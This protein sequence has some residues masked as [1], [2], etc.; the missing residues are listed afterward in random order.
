MTFASPCVDALPY[1][2]KTVV[3]CGLPQLLPMAVGGNG[4]PPFIVYVCLVL[5]KKQA[6]VS[7]VE[8]G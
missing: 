6:S 5:L 1:F 4:H 3:G 2:A 7:E 8:S